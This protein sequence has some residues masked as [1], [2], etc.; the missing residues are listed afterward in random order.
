M[1]ADDVLPPE[2]SRCH[3]GKAAG[4]HIGWHMQI[5]QLGVVGDFVDQTGKIEPGADGADGSRKDVIEHQSRN[6]ELGKRSA[7]SFMNDFVHAAAD[8][9]AA[10]F[11]VNRADGKTE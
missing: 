2:V 4:E 10:A 11:D 5:G 1:N 8:K 7:H 3:Q 6:G 9:H